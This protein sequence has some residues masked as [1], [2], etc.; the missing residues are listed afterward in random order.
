MNP[1]RKFTLTPLNHICSRFYIFRPGTPGIYGATPGGRQSPFGLH[2][3]TGVL[4]SPLQCRLTD[5]REEMWATGELAIR[6]GWVGHLAGLDHHVMC[7]VI[8]TAISA[9]T[10]NT[11]TTRPFVPPSANWLGPPWRANTTNSA[12]LGAL[13]TFP[14]TQHQT[15]SQA[16]GVAASPSPSRRRRR[17]TPSMGLHGASS[18]RWMSCLQEK[19]GHVCR[20]VLYIYNRFC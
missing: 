7:H 6:L 9:N 4:P 13:W 3:L 14:P 1:P 16:S 5:G 18:L 15:R 20:G 19:Q 11:S 12:R 10:T 8:E 2:D 17:K